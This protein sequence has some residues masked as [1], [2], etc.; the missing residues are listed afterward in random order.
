[1]TALVWDKLEERRF[2]TGIDRGV[3]YPSWGPVSVW[4]GLVSVTETG[5]REVKEYY[6]EGL[7]VFERVVPGAFSGKIEAYTYPDIL[8]LMTGVEDWAPGV[9]VHD[10]ISTRFHLCYRTR[11]S[12]ALDED[13]GYKLHLVYN[14]LANPDDVARKTIGADVEASTFSWS[15]S[16][17][18]THIENGQP[19]DHISIDSTKADPAQLQ[20]IENQ[21]YGTATT[22]P[23]MPDPLV[24]VS[25]E[26][27]PP[28]PPPP[29]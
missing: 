11:V 2:E 5:S 24:V 22:N 12:T 28:P 26:I 23:Q 4:N 1:M 6:Y 25:G 19:L 7:K 13:H 14:L 8:D 10:S 15:V 18:Q 27:P 9:Y 29:F 20:A 17:I 21:L 3:I 16:G